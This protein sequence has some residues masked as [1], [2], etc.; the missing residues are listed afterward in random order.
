MDISWLVVYAQQ[1]EEARLRKKN[2]EVKRARTDDGN[3]SKGKFEGQSGPRFKKR[4]SNQS[5]SSA[6]KTNKDRVSNP[7]PQG[8]NRGGSSIERP[9]CANCG[10]K[11]EGKCL[12]DM[13]VCYGCGKCGHQLKDCQPV[14]PIEERVIKL[15]QVVQIPMLLRRIA[16]ILSN[17]EMSKRVPRTWVMEVKSETPSLESVPVVRE[18]PKVFPD[19]LPSIPPEREIDLGIDLLPDTQPISIPPYRMALAELKELNEQLKDLLDKGF[20]QPS[21]SP[22]GALVLFI[23]NKDGSLRM[24]IDYRQLNKVTIKNKYPLPRIDDL[25]DQLQG[26]NFF[27]KIYLHSGYHQLRVRGCDIPKMAFRTRYGH[28]GFVVM[29]FWLVTLLGHIVSGMGIEVDPK[30]TDVV[31]GWPRPLTPTNIRSLLG[32]ANYYRRL[33]EGFSSIASPLTALTQ[34]KAKVPMGL[35]YIVILLEWVWDVSL[36]N[37][38]KL[39]AYALRQHKLYGVHVDIFTDHKSLQYVFSQ[40]YLNLRQRRWLEILKDYD[41]S[42][43]YHPDKANVVADSLSRFSMGSVAHVEDEKKELVRDVHRLARLGVQLV[44][45]TKG[46]FMV[47]HSS[48]SSFVVDVKSKQHLDPILMKLKESVLNKSVEAF[49]Q[50]GYGV[51]RYQGRLCISDVDG[52]REKILEESHGSRYSIHP[53]ATKMYYDLR[54][55]YWWN[56]INKDIA[57]FV[58]KC[59]NCQQVKAEHLKPGGLLQ[60]INI[61]TWKWEDVNMDFGVGVPRTRRQHDSIWVIVDRMTK[62]AHF[63]PVKAFQQGPDTNV[64]LST[65]FHPQT[66]GQA[67]RTIQTLEDILR[68]CVIDFQGNW[69]DHLPLIEFAYNNSYHSSIATTAF[70][71]LYGRRCRS[72][73]GWFEVGEFAIEKVQL[74]RERLKMAQSR[75]KSYADVRRRDLEFEESRPKGQVSSKRG[76][77]RPKAKAAQ[78]LSTLP[79]APLPSSRLGVMTTARGRLRGVA[80]DKG[81]KP[82]SVLDTT[83]T[84]TEGT[85]AREALREEDLGVVA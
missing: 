84:P 56:G 78:N 52:L 58:A 16:S 36:C 34:N 41:M 18:Y 71:A 81:G 67:E 3:S 9:T 6:P 7:K 69:D 64:R 21:I 74:I 75:Q 23:K 20:I 31:K 11:H 60:I 22:W 44:D 85:M 30:K 38:V 39:I 49:S 47:H 42:V 25:F 19:D 54:E 15:L 61:P 80:L 65:T 66:D 29:S 48:E 8:G 55:V 27:S 50:G 83:S 63:I 70:E 10:K 77:P 82:P 57:G 33:V 51:L 14:R 35:W 40:K 12:A 59:P 76:K 37:V 13:G 4:F 73:V 53:G 17:P 43:L 45:S 72:P 28:Y 26:A 79:Q 68:V 1:V 2:R 5:S 62:S 46:G 24:C 32:L